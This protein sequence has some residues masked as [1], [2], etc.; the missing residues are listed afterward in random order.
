MSGTFVKISESI[1]SGAS[2]SFGQAIYPTGGQ[3]GGIQR[4]YQV[5]LT[6]SGHIELRL[7]RDHF[8]IPAGRAIL[9]P[10]Q[11][12]ELFVFPPEMETQSIWCTMTESLVPGELRKKLLEATETI[13]ISQTLRGLI[14][15][16]LNLPSSHMKTSRLDHLERGAPQ[17]LIKN[18]S[19]HSDL[20]QLTLQLG[21][22]VLQCFV[23]DR[24]DELG[25]KNI[26]GPLP[27]EKA[28][29]H[30][31]E[32]FAESLDLAALARRASVTPNHLIKLFREHIGI[33]PVEYLWQVRLDQSVTLLRETGL[34]VSEIAYQTGFKN[35]FHFTRRFRTR[36][37]VSPRSFRRS[38]QSEISLN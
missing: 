18:L 21:L 10:P 16:G 22:C 9:C 15:L 29:Q 31:H 3:W 26:A 25:R 30:I 32:H 19:G 7:G 11:R 12:K 1:I 17:K 5:L 14:E 35:P 37:G 8:P 13:P 24:A 28:R 38:D 20:D 4:G 36:F 33:T 6:I 27:L 23:A 34:S 2:A